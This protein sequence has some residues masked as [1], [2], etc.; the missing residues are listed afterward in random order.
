MDKLFKYFKSDKKNTEAKKEPELTK[1]NIQEPL[2]PVEAV[3]EPPMNEILI[4]NTAPETPKRNEGFYYKK[5]INEITKLK[6][7]NSINSVSSYYSRKREDKDK[8]RQRD[9]R[10][11]N[12]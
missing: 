12:E 9:I 6:L 8:C 10:L 7:V 4:L 2:K 5:Y 11:F 3:P 1:F